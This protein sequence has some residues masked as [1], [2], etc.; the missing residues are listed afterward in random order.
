VGN[1]GYYFP[2][3]TL[4]LYEIPTIMPNFRKLPVL[5]GRAESMFPGKKTKLGI[6]PA[7]I[8]DNPKYPHNVGAILRACSCYGIKQLWYSG[9]RIKLD[10]A[11]RL[12]REERMRGYQEVEW[13]QYDYP[14]DQFES[15]T[16]VAIELVPGAESLV[17]FEHPDDAVYVFG[18][19]D[20]SLGH[21]ARK[22][23]HRFV[24]IPSRHCTNLSAAVYITLYD[25]MMKRVLAGKEEAP[26][27]A[28]HEQ[29]GW[30]SF[31]DEQLTL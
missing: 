7:I 15:C 13:R 17:E 11:E 20:G 9:N 30:W 23:C 1:N 6:P 14:F 29:R 10:G 8:L 21:V 25:R 27:T 4:F 22:H 16:P 19:E 31:D 26:N 12:P 18:P 28:G 2:Q 24:Q 5:P 3:N